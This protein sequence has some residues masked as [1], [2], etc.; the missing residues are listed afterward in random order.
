M[1]TPH[2]TPDDGAARR[3]PPS[4]RHL[5]RQASANSAE[6]AHLYERVAPAVYAWARLRIRPEQRRRLDPEDVVQEVWC[7]AVTRFDSFDAEQTP[8][9]AWIFRVAKYVLLEAFRSLRKTSPLGLPQDG[10]GVPSPDTFPDDATSL[11]Q[12]V[13]RNEELRAFLAY[14]ETLDDHERDLVIH[15]G[16]EGLGYDEVATRLGLSRDAAKKRWQRLRAR[17]VEHGIPRDVIES[18]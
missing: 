10:D 1:H 18:V 6:F 7:R 2:H 15:C 8:F 9:R 3:P 5:A 4:T 11:T 12:R 17:L 14:V 13:A 16:L